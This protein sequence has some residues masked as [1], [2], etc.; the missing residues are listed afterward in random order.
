[1]GD[2]TGK[3]Q[4]RR[5]L[6]EGEIEGNRVGVLGG[7]FHRF[8]DMEG[9]GGGEVEPP[10]SGASHRLQCRTSPPPRPVPATNPS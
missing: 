9:E 10:T 3:D 1:M 5:V 7:V 8:L 4:G 6:T 2:P